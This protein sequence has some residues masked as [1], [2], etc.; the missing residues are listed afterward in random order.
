MS[1]ITAD[2]GARVHRPLRERTDNA[3]TR[4]RTDRRVKTLLYVALSLALVPLAAILVVTTFQ[5]LG[6]MSIEFFTELPP[7]RITEEG[8]GYRSAFVGTFYMVGIATVLSVPLGILAAVFLVEYD[9]GLLV[10]PTRFFTDVMTGVPSIFVGLFVLSALIRG[11]GI[12]RSPLAGGIALAILMLPIVVRSA[13]EVLKLVP[14]D[15]RNAAYGLGARRWQSVIRVVLPA[16]APGLITGTLLA[17]AR[18]IGETAPLLLAAVGLR[19]VQLTLFE[20][21]EQIYS[22]ALTLQAFDEARSFAPEAQE[23][24]WGGAFSLIVIVLVLN[25]LARLIGRRSQVT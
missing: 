6:A 23:R 25:V 2:A 9:E 4:A 7:F 20:P 22:N 1:D 15:L 11:V 13:E 17:I 8:G 24:G 10:R 12:G 16:A 18:A 19:D 21:G 3:A 5:G 14:Q